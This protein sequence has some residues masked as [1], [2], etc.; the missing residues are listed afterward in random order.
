MTIPVP[1]VRRP[2]SMASLTLSSFRPCFL[3]QAWVTE[4]EDR[5]EQ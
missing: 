1:T 2:C 5:E 4:Q 3:Y